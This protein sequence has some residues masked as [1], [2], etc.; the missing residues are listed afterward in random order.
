MKVPAFDGVNQRWDQYER[1]YKPLG[2]TQ[3]YDVSGMVHFDSGDVAY[4]MTGQL[5]PDAR[6][7]YSKYGIDITTTRNIPAG[8]RG[9]DGSPLTKAGLNKRGT[10]MVYIDTH[11]GKAWTTRHYY[12]RPFTGAAIMPERLPEHLKE[13]TLAWNHVAPDP[14]IHGQF[15]Y[16]RRRDRSEYE[17][18]MDWMS[19]VEVICRIK[20]PGS[21]DR[22]IAPADFT[23]N[24]PE[25]YPD[26]ADYIIA[27][28]EVALRIARAGFSLGFELQHINYIA[29]P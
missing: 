15:S 12:R 28:P 25:K 4:Y 1:F 22:D 6:H 26:P 5:R 2:G 16:W 7:K 23:P 27:H 14:F 20:H 13:A 11:T 8:V 24:L 29:M 21:I 9:P 17:G 19:T 10:Q 18:H 3:R